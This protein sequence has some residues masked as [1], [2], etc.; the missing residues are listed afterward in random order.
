MPPAIRTPANYTL[1]AMIA[2]LICG[3]LYALVCI[4]GYFDFGS[5]KLHGN[6]ILLM[7]NPLK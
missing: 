2:M 4:F 7:Y 3:T 1:S 6:S 5:T